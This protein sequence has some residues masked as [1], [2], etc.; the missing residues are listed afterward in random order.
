MGGGC[1]CTHILANE[2]LE[3]AK[4]MERKIALEEGSGRMPSFF[5]FF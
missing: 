5:F 2:T 1:K 3:P 4:T